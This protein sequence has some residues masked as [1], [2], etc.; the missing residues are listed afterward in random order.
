MRVF[1][2]FDNIS[3]EVPSEQTCRA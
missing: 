3:E 1:V 2:I